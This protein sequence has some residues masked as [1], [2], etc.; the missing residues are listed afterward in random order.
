MGDAVFRKIALRLAAFVFAGCLVGGLAGAV[1][2]QTISQPQGDTQITGPG[3]GQ[4]FTAT[5][6]GTVTRIDFRGRS[7]TATTL[8]IYNGGNGSGTGGSVGAPAYQQAVTLVDSTS[9]ASGFTAI[10]LTTP[11]PV[12]A[13][14]TYSFVFSAGNTAVTF[15]NPYAGGTSISDFVTGGFTGDTPFQIYEVATPIPVPTLSEWAM[16]LLGLVLAGGAALYIQR[17]QMTV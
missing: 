11:F 6:T 14:Q 13:G 4:T 15:G 17:R 3:V 2:A 10:T 5:L 8:N 16:I 7:N 9:N 1:A 12:V